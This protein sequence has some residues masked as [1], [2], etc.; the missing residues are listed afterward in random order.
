MSQNVQEDGQQT[1]KQA[2]Q[3]TRRM[4]KATS[5]LVLALTV[6]G[7]TTAVMPE[8]RAQSAEALRHLDSAVKNSGGD[9][10]LLNHYREYSCD[11]VEDTGMY[12]RSSAERRETRVPLTQIFDNVW[13]IGDMYVGQFILK[14]ASGGFV[15]IDALN[16]SAEVDQYTMPALRSLG[17]SA[18]N[19]LLAVMISHGHGDHDG[20][21]NRLREIFGSSLA[22]YLGSG[23]ARNKAYNPLQI[24]SAI[25]EPQERTIGGTTVV[26]QSIPGHTPGMMN[27]VI[28]VRHNGVEHK[29]MM[30]GRQGHPGAVASARSYLRG[31]ERSYELV[32]KYGVVGTFLTH[33]TS[34]GTTVHMQAI[35]RAG[36]RDPNPFFIGHERTLR[37]AAMWRGCAAGWLSTRDASSVELVWRVTSL[38]FPELKP[39]LNTVSAQLASGWGPNDP[40]AAQTTPDAQWG[41]IAGQTVTFS[42]EGGGPGCTAITNAKGLATCTLPNKAK[43]LPN[44]RVAASFEGN[45]TDT[46]VNLSSKASAVVPARGR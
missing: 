32:K 11:A 7:V 40:D 5:M 39:N 2:A 15:L 1:F 35:E 43:L 46:F 24:D 12:P 3:P 4:P 25:A 6:A 18:S 41:P 8:A 34:D 30:G 26:F 29:L 19:P 21:A 22:I 20:G 42:I 28:P 9:L 14:T 44:Q 37:A 45:T 13:Y 23:D 38:T 10:A 17:L 16:N 27:F 36:S 33:P 31:T